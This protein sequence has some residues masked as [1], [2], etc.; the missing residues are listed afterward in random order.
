MSIPML[1]DRRENVDGEEA[2]GAGAQSEREPQRQQRPEGQRQAAAGNGRGDWR[3]PQPAA[4]GG[5]R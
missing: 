4:H 5:K 1:A 3:E 2:A